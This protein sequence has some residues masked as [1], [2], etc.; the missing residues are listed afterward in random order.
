MTEIASFFGTFLQ[1]NKGHITE[2]NILIVRIPII[3]NKTMV[4]QKMKEI[5]LH[6]ILSTPSSLQP[7]MKMEMVW[8]ASRGLLS[9]RQPRKGLSPR[10]EGRKMSARK[11][12]SVRQTEIKEGG[13]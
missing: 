12:P 7:S 5:S 4:I 10:G 3:A 6:P 9:L 2:K 8:K 11:A 13:Q 1:T